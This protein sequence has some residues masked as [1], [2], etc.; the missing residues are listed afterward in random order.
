VTPAA[1]GVYFEGEWTEL[2][3]APDAPHVVYSIQIDV[4][5][6]RQREMDRLL[7]RELASNPALQLASVLG[8]LHLYLRL[9]PQREK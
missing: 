3:A 9:R 5:K 8:Q 4:A 7:A 1:G 6:E 2:R